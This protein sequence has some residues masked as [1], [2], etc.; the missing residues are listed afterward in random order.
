MANYNI[1][2]T[3]HYQEADIEFGGDSRETDVVI[4]THEGITIFE[5]QF[6]DEYHNDVGSSVEAFI[7]GV[8]F[9]MDREGSTVDISRSQIAD[10]EF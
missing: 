10:W 2:V 4:T 9:M 1:A 3:T 8:T 6:G 5:E 7:K